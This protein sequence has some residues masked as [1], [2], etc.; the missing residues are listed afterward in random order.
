MFVTGG[1]GSSVPAPFLIVVVFWL[2][3]IFG[4]FGIFAPR[5]TTVLVVLFIC[6]LSVAGSIFLVLEMDQPFRG[7]MKISSSPLRYTLSH[8]GQ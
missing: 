3:F 4:C 2:T 6:A 8:L 7:M 1:L 5:N